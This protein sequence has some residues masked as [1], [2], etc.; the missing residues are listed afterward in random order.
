MDDELNL[1]GPPSP[2]IVAAT[3]YARDVA[4][5][6]MGIKIIDIEGGHAV[7]SMP[8]RADMIQGHN[9]CHGGMIFSLADTAFA[10]ACNSQNQATVAAGCNIEFLKPAF[11]DDLLTADARQLT[12]SGRTGI[13]DVRVSNQHGEIIAVFRGKSAAIKEQVI[14]QQ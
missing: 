6:S 12:L 7:A 1:P 4:A 9:T 13:Y 8:V 14:P 3:M 11:L 2:A 10:Y 5:Q